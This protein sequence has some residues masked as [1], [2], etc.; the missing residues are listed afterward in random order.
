MQLLLIRER[1]RMQKQ[2]QQ[3]T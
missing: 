1:E 3:V 2:Q